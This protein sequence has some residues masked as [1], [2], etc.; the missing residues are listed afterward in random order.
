MPQRQRREQDN[1]REERHERPA[2]AAPPQTGP[3]LMGWVQRSAGNQAAVRLARQ[4][5]DAP[6]ET[7]TAPEANAE[8][9]AEELRS[10][11]D[12][13]YGERIEITEG[14]LG[15]LYGSSSE[16]GKKFKHRDAKY[17]EYKGDFSGA[18]AKPEDVEQGALGDCYLLSALA[19]VARANPKAIEDLIKDN[20]DGT[21]DVTIYVDKAWV[22][23]KFEKKTIN[24]KPTF[25]T[26]DGSPLYAAKGGEGP[27]G[28]RLWVMLIEKAFAI[29]KGSYPAME[30]G[31]GGPAMEQITGKASERVD[32]SDKSEKELADLIDSKMKGGAAVTAAADWVLLS[33]T[34]KK[35]AAEGVPSLQHEYAVSG[36]DKSAMTIDLQNP[37]GFSHITALP[38]SKFKQ[39]FRFIDYN[40]AK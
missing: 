31:F 35:A 8:K 32:L 40:Q 27:K 13:L 29:H 16:P 18:G 39:W 21:F 25:P 22:G 12:T 15:L 26:K 30:G 9:A 20:G 7:A 14:L 17:E 5:T 23:K 3:E 19:A 1:E 37:W 2:A 10:D 33:S 38:F 4:T 11:S 6:P 36:V 28:P 24:V 34:K